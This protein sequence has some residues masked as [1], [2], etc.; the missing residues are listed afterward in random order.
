ML[1]WGGLPTGS[2]LISN[3]H[4]YLLENM[5]GGD[6]KYKWSS[7]STRRQNPKQVGEADCLWCWG[8]LPTGS[9][10]AVQSQIEGSLSIL[11]FVNKAKTKM[12]LSTVSTQS[13]MNIIGVFDNPNNTTNKAKFKKKICFVQKIHFD[14]T[15]SGSPTHSSQEGRGTW[16]K[17][18][19]TPLKFN[20]TLYSG[21]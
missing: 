8:K 18:V 13:Q 20:S 3:Q 11:S 5:I 21:D 15:W 1:I 17:P 16:L 10:P 4:N 9:T 7:R 19:P 2:A 12:I 14:C 6:E